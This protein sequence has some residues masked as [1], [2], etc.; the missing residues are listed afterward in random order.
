MLLVLRNGFTDTRRAS[1]AP[2]AP[3]P[4]TTYIRVPLIPGGRIARR[5]FHETTVA[6]ITRR[7]RRG[8]RGL[9]R[10][11]SV[12]SS[13]SSIR[14]VRPIR[15]VSSR[16]FTPRRPWT[17][18]RRPPRLRRPSG[19]RLEAT[20]TFWKRSFHTATRPME[21]RR[22]IHRGMDRRRYPRSYREVPRHPSA[23]AP[24]VRRDPPRQPRLRLSPR[25]TRA[26]A[27]PLAQ[28]RAR[29]SRRARRRRPCR[30]RRRACRRPP[31]PHPPP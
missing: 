13:S 3:G 24:S 17:G 31:P 12:V 19:R 7:Q 11:W 18:P 6:R 27:P 20:L 22:G 9:P 23:R 8:I 16:S 29:A 10:A 30:R 4:F 28:S 1:C 26:I 14:V 15:L 21:R 25:R 2:R 5:E